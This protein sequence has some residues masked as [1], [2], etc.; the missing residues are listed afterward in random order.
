MARER[1]IGRSAGFPTDNDR[2]LVRVSMGQIW[3]LRYGSEVY[4]LTLGVRSA[5]LVQLPRDDNPKDHV[6]RCV[7]VL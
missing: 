6:V 3:T 2:V 5:R 4:D 1:R 7:V